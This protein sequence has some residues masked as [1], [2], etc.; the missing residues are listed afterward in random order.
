M[1]GAPRLDPVASQGYAQDFGQGQYGQANQ[2]LY[3][4]PNGAVGAY[5]G[6]GYGPGAYGFPGQPQEQT[7]SVSDKLK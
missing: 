4:Q 7:A 2:Q 5:N 3:S 6:Y 1:P